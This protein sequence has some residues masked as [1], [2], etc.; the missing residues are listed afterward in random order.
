[1]L[2]INMIDDQEGTQ[3]GALWYTGIVILNIGFVN[4][5]KTMYSDLSWRQ[6][7][8]QASKGPEKPLC[9]KFGLQFGMS[10]FA[11]GSADVK[12]DGSCFFSAVQ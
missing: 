6:T 1:M 11:K 5:F 8:S 12:G 2:S 3:N 9:C 4:L 10:N 7:F